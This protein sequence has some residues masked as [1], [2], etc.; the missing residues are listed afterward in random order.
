M[1]RHSIHDPWSLTVHEDLVKIGVRCPNISLKGMSD[2]LDGILFR[3]H[4]WAGCKW[5]SMGCASYYSDTIRK[6]WMARWL[7]CSRRNSLV[8]CFRQ[9]NGKIWSWSMS[10]ERRHVTEDVTGISP[11]QANIKCPDEN[12][13]HQLEGYPSGRTLPTFHVVFRPISTLP[14]TSIYINLDLLVQTTFY[15]LSRV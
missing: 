11:I 12:V 10:W 9:R 5:M 14:S 2:V 4:R 15:Y 1:G 13:N 6:Q 7:S 3:W 8:R